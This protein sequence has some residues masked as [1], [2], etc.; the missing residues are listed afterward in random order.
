[1]LR[2]VPVLKQRPDTPSDILAVP[3]QRYLLPP[4]IV[5]HLREGFSSDK[6]VIQVN[7][8]P[9]AEVIGSQVVVGDVIG[10]EAAS[11]RSHP[12]ITACRQPLSVTLHL[13]AIVNCRTGRWN[14]SRFQGVGSVS[15]RAH[16]SQPIRVTSLDNGVSDLVG[17]LPSTEQFVA[18]L[19]CHSMTQRP[20][21]LASYGEF[22]HVEELDLR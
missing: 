17:V 4:R 14:P 1:M 8:T 5:G 22:S 13:C 12:F 3:D 11:D 2:N 6:F 10:V 19:S 16:L 15:P 20:G 21:G 18:G 7:E 9:V